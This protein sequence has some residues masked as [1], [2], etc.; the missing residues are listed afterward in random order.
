MIE[1]EVTIIRLPGKIAWPV[2]YIPDSFGEA[3][4]SKNR[5][6]VLAVVDGA[7]FRGT[8]L[9][10]SNGHYLVYSQAMRK[11]CGKEIGETVHVTLEVD[12]QPRELELPEDVAAALHGTGAAME[13]FSSLPYYI[14][15]DEI[16][17]INDAKTQ[18]TRER[19]IKALVDRL[20]G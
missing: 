18:P 15:R 7:E 5:I 12:D 9:P 10:S 6:N 11:H 1:F 14:R 20:Q 17:K 8:L 4:G 13:K 2:F 3:V 16:N 19:R